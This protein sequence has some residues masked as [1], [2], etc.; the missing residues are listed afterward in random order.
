MIIAN[1][2]YS[3]I[4]KAVSDG[5]TL[6]LECNGD[7]LSVRLQWIDAPE[8]Q[9]PG[10]SSEDSQIIKHWE[11]AQKAKSELVRIIDKQ[12]LLLIP[13]SKDYY[14]RWLC[15]LYIGKVSLT[16]NV[17]IQLCKAGMATSYLPFNRHSYNSRELSLLKGIITETALANRKKIGIWSEPDFILPH[18]FKKLTF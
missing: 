15:D 7:R 8:T 17:Q 4:Q 14:D 2:V 16:T 10:S 6:S 5:D 12:K 18:E 11:W 9:K 3:S 1:K 13:T